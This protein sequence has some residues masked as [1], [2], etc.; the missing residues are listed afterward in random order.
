M[1]L[2]SARPLD[3]RTAAPFGI[4]R[5]THSEFA[6]F[7]VEL[8]AG[9]VIGRGEAA[10]NARYGESRDAGL[11]LLAALAPKSTVVA[12]LKFVPVIVTVAPPAR[13]PTAGLTLVTVGAAMYVN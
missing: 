11:E 2:V 6:D 7:V 9:D 8:R 10:P 12:P 13:G 5:W 3:L 4:A 1:A